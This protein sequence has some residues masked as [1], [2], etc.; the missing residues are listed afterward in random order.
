MSSERYL[1]SDT[2]KIVHELQTEYWIMN[3]DGSNKTR[4]MFYN[5]KVG[6][7]IH[8]VCSDNS[9]NLEIRLCFCEI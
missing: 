7:D 8:I 1:I 3:A 5:E 6:D 4:I 9:W 2:R